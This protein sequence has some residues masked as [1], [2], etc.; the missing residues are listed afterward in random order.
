MNYSFDNPKAPN[1]KKR[2][3]YEMFGNRA[4]WVDGWKA[5]TLHANRMPWDVNV[6]LPFDQDKWE[7]YH[8]AEDFSEKSL[9]RKHGSTMS[10]RFTMT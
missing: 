1:A 10:I 5:V 8:V 3:Y 2:Q 6:V 4:I 9:I 7:L